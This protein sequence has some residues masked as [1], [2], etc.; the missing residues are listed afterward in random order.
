[1]ACTNTIV[2]AKAL[3]HLHNG[4]PF[5]PSLV[6]TLQSLCESTPSEAETKIPEPSPK[7]GRRKITK[8]A[9]PS[10]KPAEPVIPEPKAE[11]EAEA[12][13]EVEPEPEPEAEAEAEPEAEPAVVTSIPVYVNDPY[14]THKYRLQT[15]DPTKCMGRKCVNT[16]LVVGTRTEDKA[17]GANGRIYIEFQ[18]GNLPA[19]PGLSPLCETHLNREAKYKTDM[20]KV[21]PEWFGRHDETELYHN[22][23]IIGSGYFFNKYPKGLTND[24]MTAP[25]V[26]E[27][28][29]EPE[30]PSGD[31]KVPAKA[32]AKRGPKV[33]VAAPVDP[34]KESVAVNIA[35]KEVEWISFKHEGRMH[36][37]N[38]QTGSVYW[39]DPTKKKSTPA[40]MAVKERY[41]G[42]WIDG[43]LD[44]LAD[45]DDDE[46]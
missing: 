46:E 27:L 44:T 39:I 2:F 36:I 33:K 6:E 4:T 12:E 31:E 24:P 26:N 5:E 42:K 28:I 10:A 30:L 41:V 14:K 9:T 13:P 21:W 15:L 40:E 38:V 25:P 7:K 29:L 8:V 20:N 19:N 16:H 34:P 43:A 45:T 17:I 32:K 18:C 11:A 1:M 37:R 35:P 3:L 23:R 22:S